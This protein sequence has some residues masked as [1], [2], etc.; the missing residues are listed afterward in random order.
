MNMV[1]ITFIK[2]KNWR[3][4]VYNIFKKMSLTKMKKGNQNKSRRDEL[5]NRLEKNSYIN[6]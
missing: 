4:N 3:I 2:R 1:S 5:G 6:K